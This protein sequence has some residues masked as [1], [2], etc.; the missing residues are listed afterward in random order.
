MAAGN[1]VICV[2]GSVPVQV[3]VPGDVPVQV[4]VSVDW[5]NAKGL[6]SRRNNAS[7]GRFMET[8]S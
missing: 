1:A 7:K 2:P 4:S 6:T 5:A 8:P 3:S